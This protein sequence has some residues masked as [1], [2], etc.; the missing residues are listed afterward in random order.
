MRRF[1]AA[2]ALVVATALPLMQQSALGA[3]AA[4]VLSAASAASAASAV[5]AVSGGRLRVELADGS[6]GP[7]TVAGVG[8]Y[9]GAVEFD[10]V[11]GALS[12]V[13]T[14]GLED[15]L[16][17]V[18][19]VPSTWPAAAL[20]AQ[21]V[22]AR[23]Y[24]LWHMLVYHGR[25]RWPGT[26]ADICANDACQ[27]Y[28]GVD[29]DRRLNAAAWD[30]AVSATAGEVLLW[31]GLVIQSMYSSSN[32]GQSV[33]GGVPW[34]P[35]AADPD[36]AASPLHHW[37]WTAPVAAFAPVLGISPTGLVGLRT[38]AGSVVATV[39]QQGSAPTEQTVDPGQFRSSVNHQLAP[40]T[41][42]PLALPSSR[43]ALTTDPSGNVTVDGG[44]WGHGVGMSQ[45]GALGKARTGLSS[46]A[47]LAAYYGP[48]RPVR[49]S[50][51]QLNTAIRVLLAQ[52][53]SAASVTGAGPLRVV[54]GRGKV[55]GLAP[56]GVLSV[57]SSGNGV[58]A[59]NVSPPAGVPGPGTA[60][61]RPAPHVV[62]NGP[63][64][65]LVAAGVPGT[66]AV[67]STRHRL[68]PVILASAA[69]ILLVVAGATGRA[70][71]R[72]RRLPSS[73]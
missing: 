55:L 32:G 24:A 26:D 20:E 21:A 65:H 15:Y 36:D 25:S 62:R 59:D 27:V 6:Q 12:L 50:A 42:L 67:A 45:Y 1:I 37:T 35:S 69:A 43:Y 64:S 4:S 13:N 44:G 7:L 41:G 22:A 48:A 18:A 33:S 72:G 53:V 57:H 11:R 39:Q 58:V 52:N 47:I 68:K 40:P 34:L 46:A 10:G 61:T 3:P 9:R 14:V 60:T 29:N 5:S 73:R 71:T 70:A 54:D 49:F 56:G 28:R 31:K 2:V 19:E 51:D 17:G 30:A 63:P 38:T 23:T 8:T 16:R 66:K